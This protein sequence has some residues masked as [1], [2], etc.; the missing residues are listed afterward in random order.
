M[1]LIFTTLNSGNQS[2]LVRRERVQKKGE[3][4]NYNLSP[5]QK[6]TGGGFMIFIENYASMF[7]CII[8]FF[9]FNGEWSADV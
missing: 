7:I 2:R 8:Q 4:D 3:S 5:S 1:T 9:F 6:P